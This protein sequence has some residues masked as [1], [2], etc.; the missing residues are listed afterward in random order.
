MVLV[1]GLSKEKAKI[2]ALLK[3]GI[4]L[5]FL[6]LVFE[7]ALRKWFLPFLASPLLV[8]RDPLALWILL[9]AN[10]QGFLPRSIY[11]TA[12]ILVGIIA[13]FLA[14][15]VGHGNFAVALFGARILVIHFPLM[16]AM[17]KI[18]NR[19]DVIKLGKA[20][21]WITLPMTVL[22]A[23]QFY[24]P[25]SAWVN[26]GVGG[27]TAGAGFTGS[28]GFF[29]PPGT[30]SFTNGTTLFY[31]FVSCFILYFW[32]QPKTTLNKLILL[33][34]TACLIAAIP[35]SISRSL[36]FQVGI[37]A[38][39]A[40][41]AV[42][43]NPKYLGRVL[44]ASFGAII[45]IIILSQVSFFKT[46]IEAFTDRFETA[47]EIEGGVQSVLADR[48]LGGLIG[49]LTES[50]TQPLFGHGIG[51]GTN[52]GSN[53][54]TGG[55]AFLISEGEWGRLIGEMGPYLGILAIFIRLGFSF[56]ITKASF[57]KLGLNDFLP[58]MLLSFGLLTV[59]QAQ[60]AQPTSLGFSTMIGG[61]MIAALNKK[62]VT[63]QLK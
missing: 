40:L 44:F 63:E 53:L 19:E 60:W 37:C 42:L 43:K 5:Y 31:G 30:F 25:Q 50:G 9:V 27:D 2:L 3:K 46:S 1:P 35:L 34:A 39:F 29:R 48:Y 59:P 20:A 55:S 47:N 26:R 8:I 14:L 22:I 15:F 38:I 4:W 16:F 57:R 7:G 41:L 36:F 54:L 13:F 33:S 28:M 23:M 51:M 17:G 56:E 10:W 24:S 21:V 12:M 62:V 58:W 45:L 52:V 49:A 18:F 61:L 6:L 32:I 11:L